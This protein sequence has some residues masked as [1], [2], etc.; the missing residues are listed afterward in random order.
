MIKGKDMGTMPE[1]EEHEGTKAKAIKEKAKASKEHAG[2]ATR[3][4]IRLKAA[5]RR[6]TVC[7]S[8]EK[9]PRRTT[10]G[11]MRSSEMMNT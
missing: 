9:H 10:A 3:S 1:K 4:G 11:N 8:L 2:L 6:K 7:I 5:P